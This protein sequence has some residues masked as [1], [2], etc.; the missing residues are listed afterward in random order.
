MTSPHSKITIEELLN[1]ITGFNPG[2]E[3]I[4]SRFQNRKNGKNQL[5]AVSR[6]GFSGNKDDSSSDDVITYQENVVL[7]DTKHDLE[8]VISMLN[9]MRERK[10]S[11][12]QICLSLFTLMKSFSH[13]G[14]EKFLSQVGH[15]N[16]DGDCISK[17][18]DNAYWFCIW[19]RLCYT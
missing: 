16:A 11:G 5:Y 13:R 17:G 3:Q 1:S 8:L 2:L 10:A 9:Y 19:K 18:I 6:Y 15:S 4:T 12:E 7:P 14:K